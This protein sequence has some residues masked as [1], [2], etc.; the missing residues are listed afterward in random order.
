[1]RAAPCLA[2]AL[3]LALVVLGAGCTGTPRTDTFNVDGAGRLSIALAPEIEANATVVN[4]TGNVI[5]SRVILTAP[6]GVPVTAYVAA[7]PD[8]VAAVVY[9]PGANEPVSGHA[10]RFRTYPEAGIA[11]CYLDVR[12]NGFETPGEPLDR[13]EQFE[14]FRQDRWPQTYR[15]VADVMRART[16]LAGEYGVPAWALGSSDGGRYAAIAAGIDPGFAGYAGVSTSPYR[17]QLGSGDLSRR[18][19]ASIDPATY[20]GGISPR[21]VVLYHAEY[22]PVIPFAEGK[23]LFAA[24]REP[25]SF[26]V[27]AGPHGIS[28][29]VDDDLLGRLT[30]VYGS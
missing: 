10:E 19:T 24:A 28:P 17:A 18:F 11:F 26:V 3:I 22:D 6:D 21:P 8:P 25:K 5:L 23:A 2:L 7:P 13:R 1:M 27:F 12:G 20:I 4:T 16:Y 14:Q 9:V 15:I 29:E 30:Q